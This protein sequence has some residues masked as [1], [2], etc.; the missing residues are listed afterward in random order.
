MTTFKGVLIGDFSVGKTSICQRMH[1][2]SFDEM[3]IPTVGGSYLRLSVQCADGSRVEVAL[4]D[5]AGH[6]RFRT[7]VPMYF[8]QVNFV[9]VVFDLTCQTSFDNIDMWTN[10]ASQKSP[11]D[12]KFVLVGNKNDLMDKREIQFDVA[13][14]KANEMKAVAYIETSACTGAGFDSLQDEIA[15]IAHEM[16][17]SAPPDDTKNVPDVAD[18]AIADSAAAQPNRCC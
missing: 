16:T 15:R 10:L 6:E 8:R 14:N 9:L 4:W 17:I 3:H 5:T 7:I 12:V 2:G 11:T 13:Q 18:V 1:N